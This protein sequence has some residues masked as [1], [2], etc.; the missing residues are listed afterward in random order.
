MQV[1][2]HIPIETKINFKKALQGDSPQITKV[3]RTTEEH[4]LMKVLGWP[5]ELCVWGKKSH[6]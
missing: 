3:R 2:S 1:K 4:Y 5:D 6:K